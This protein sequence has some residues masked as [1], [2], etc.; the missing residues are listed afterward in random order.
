MPC[1][2]R[3]FDLLRNSHP[4][5]PLYTDGV[6]LLVL[7]ALVTSGSGVKNKFFDRLNERVGSSEPTLSLLLTDSKR[8]NYSLLLAISP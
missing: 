7:T 8:G 1:F 2:A 3:C 4:R 5:V 6:E